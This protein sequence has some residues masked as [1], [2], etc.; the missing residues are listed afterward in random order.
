MPM[1]FYWFVKKNDGDSNSK[2]IVTVNH[3][4]TVITTVI[5]L[6]VRV[7]IRVDIAINA[8]QLLE[9]LLRELEMVIF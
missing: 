8:T 6:T 5:G 4:V 3:T 7:R 1:Y 2:K 9:F